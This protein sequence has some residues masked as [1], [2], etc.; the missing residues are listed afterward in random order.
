VIF[1]PS[2]ERIARLLVE[3]MC[4]QTEPT[5]RAWFKLACY[6]C[7]V[8]NLEEAKRRVAA[9]ISLDQQY[10]LMALDDPDLEPL[11]EDLEVMLK[12]KT[13]EFEA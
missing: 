13:K 2:N 1:Q 10:R 8:G 5:L 6:A 3:S 4:G 12:E 11:W 9:A 7:Q